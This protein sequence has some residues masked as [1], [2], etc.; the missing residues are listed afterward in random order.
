M[1]ARFSRRSNSTAGEGSL[2]RG[3]GGAFDCAQGGTCDGPEGRLAA[4][5]GDEPDEGSRFPYI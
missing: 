5:R 3:V 2:A 4:A 1:L